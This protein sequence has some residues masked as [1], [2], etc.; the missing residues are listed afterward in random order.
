MSFLEVSDISVNYGKTQ[1]LKGVSFAMEKGRIVS[2]IGANG[3]GKSTLLKT[4]SGLVKPQSGAMSYNG[5]PLP[6]LAHQVV[7]LGIIQVPEGRKIFSALTVEENLICGAYLQKNRREVEKL[8]QQQYETFPILKERK[9]Q[10]GATLSGGEQQMLAIARALMGS[11]KLLL[12]DEP[13]LGL[14]PKVVDSVF[15]NIMR[16]RESGITVLLVEQNAR[17][18]LLAADDAFVLEDGRIAFSGTGEAL[19]HDERIIQSY[20][21]T[22]KSE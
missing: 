7:R 21:G 12:L 2:I 16:I 18:A 5:A 9:G 19:L 20:L 11:P 10:H 13:S 8:L 6:Q 1:A 14:A 22:K 4:I 3:A 15:K 17:R